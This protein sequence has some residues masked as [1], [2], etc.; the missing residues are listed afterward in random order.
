MVAIHHLVVLMVVHGGGESFEMVVMVS[1]V[2]HLVVVVVI[3]HGGNGVYWNLKK[4]K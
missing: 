2:C 1:L 3:Y 4:Q